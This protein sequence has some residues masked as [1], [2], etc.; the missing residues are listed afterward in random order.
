MTV[1]RHLKG[2]SI[3]STVVKRLEEIEKSVSDKNTP[4]LIMIF[5]DEHGRFVEQQTYNDG[6]LK[7][8]QIRSLEEY[9]PPEGF[10]GPLII[11]DEMHG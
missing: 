2:K 8:R 3:K 4:I 5:K 7:R 1:L 6:C 9:Q 11:E 10:K